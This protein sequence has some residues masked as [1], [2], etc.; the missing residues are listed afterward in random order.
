M[1]YG[2]GGIDSFFE[3]ASAQGNVGLSVGIT[4]PTMPSIPEIFL[5]FGMW[6]GRIEIIPALVLFKVGIDLFKRF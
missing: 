3:I 4:S 2:Y 5:I 1:Q 6:I